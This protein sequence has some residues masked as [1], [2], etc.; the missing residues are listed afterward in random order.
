MTTGWTL[1][2][3]VGK[4]PLHQCRNQT[5]SDDALDN[6]L[7]SLSLPVTEQRQGHAAVTFALAAV[8][9]PGNRDDVRFLQKFFAE[10]GT[11]HVVAWYSRPDVE[12]RLWLMD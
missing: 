1:R 6:N 7:E 5:G 4:L 8:A 11:R 9:R 3:S 12:G 10:V 2:P